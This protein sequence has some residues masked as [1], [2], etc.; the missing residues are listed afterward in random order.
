M[1]SFRTIGRFEIEGERAT[2]GA[3]TVYA[4]R[5][6][7]TG[8]RVAVKLI[9][10]LAASDLARFR[11]EVDT[12]AQLRHPAVVRYVDHGQIGSGT[13]YLAMELLEGEDLRSRL[14][15]GPLSF[16]ETAV[17]GQRVAEALAAVHA[18]RLVHRDV[19]PAN[20]FLAGGQIAGA[21]LVDFGLVRMDRS[22]LDTDVTTTGIVL[23]TPAYMSPEQARGLRGI[24][25]RADIFALGC[26]LYR[27][28]AGR[29]P[30]EGKHVVSVLTK[31]ILEPAPS[32][33]G[34]R[35]GVPGPLADLI[36]RMLEKDPDRR[37]ASATVVARALGALLPA[38]EAAPDSSDEAPPSSRSGLTTSEMRIA[39]VLMVG[40]APLGDEGGALEKVRALAA[41]HS[42]RVEGLREG[43]L[44]ITAAGDALVSDQASR[45]AE[46]A[47]ALRAVLPGAPMAIATGRADVGRR[48]LIGDAIERAALLLGTSGDAAG[49]AVGIAVDD[50]TAALLDPRFEIERDGAALRL[51]GARLAEA[52]ARTVLGRATP[53]L[54]R[55]WEMRSIETF[56][57]ECVEE[58]G[59]RPVL[60]TGAAGMG[61]SRLAHEVV[62]SLRR[63]TPDLEVWWGRGDPLHSES[64]LGVLGQLLRSAAGIGDGDPPD[65]R[66]RRFADLVRARLSD[67]PDWMGA[68]LG[69]AAGARIRGD[70]GATGPDSRA[71]SERIGAA[72]QA[73]VDATC[74]ARPLILVLNDLQWVDGPTVQ[75]VGAALT[76][77]GRRPWLVLG[78][79][80]PEI[81]E[82]HPG[83]WMEQ[84][85]QELRLRALSR[86]AS[87]EL[88]REVLGDTASADT[89]ER[90][91]AHA[92]GNA[93]YLEELIRAVAESRRTGAPVGPLPETVLGMVQAR[94][95]GLDSETRRVLRAASIFGDVFWLDGVA[96]LLGGA[97]PRAAVDALVQRELVSLA[98][99][100]RFPG[101]VEL[102]FR[103]ALLREGAYAM[104]T[105]ADRENGH[106]LAGEWLLQHGETDP[107][108]LAHHFEMAGDRERAAAYARMAQGRTTREPKRA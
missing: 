35:P 53:M 39:A 28:L 71:S 88:A 9:R 75:V 12:L 10:G 68:A 6:P 62:A 87:V 60:V 13:A 54:G 92:D 58:P 96:E 69:D 81:H 42:G 23:G 56:F 26:V 36:G 20:V 25:A 52:P 104:L 47:L 83:L 27:C 72:W 67:R 2:G 107:T 18:H 100:S 4:G 16:H 94:L 59:A 103:H 102:S 19:K 66:R 63:A 99:G 90:L 84:G 45:V 5:D 29:P 89:I 57:R 24:D 101:E 79:A 8:M 15:R 93:F 22:G 7:S 70:A 31:V 106:A 97:L 108:V 51:A 49:A 78:L 98:S 77:L 38:L 11:R 3:G 86:R 43:T 76:S 14:A 17:L 41:A 95:A 46:I 61:K 64:P 40:G 48:W 80:R 34:A 37:P 1:A 85:A 30:F 32:L 50:V 74:A 21:T 105:P 33:R 91:A 82:R 65:V 73:L 44:V 55:E